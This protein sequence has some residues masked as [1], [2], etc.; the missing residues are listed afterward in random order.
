MNDFIFKGH[1]S[2]PIKTLNVAK[3]VFAV[4][5]TF[6]EANDQ[7]RNALNPAFGFKLNKGMTL[8]CTYAAFR[9]FYGKSAFDFAI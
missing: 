3:S 1:L 7:S 4:A 8:V 5:T 2:N 9:T 6:V